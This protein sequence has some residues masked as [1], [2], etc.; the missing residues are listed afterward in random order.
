MPIATCKLTDRD[1]EILEL[2]TKRVRVLSL[3]QV[4]R[5]W[6]ARQAR[7][8]ENASR[9]LST[10]EQGGLIHR[11]SGFAHPE[12]PLEK[13]VATWS[14]GSPSPD[15][16]NLS[17]RLRTRWTDPL[18]MT[19]AFIGTK[20]AAGQ[21][22]GNGGRVPRPSELSHDLHLAGVFFKLRRSDPAKSRTW[23]SEASQYAKGGGRDERLPDAVVGKG[24]H[25][26]AIEFG[27][28][29]SKAKLI[30]FHEHCAAS[31]LPYEIW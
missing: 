30:E 18:R 15:F 5:E 23:L 4:A 3:E 21:F 27:G 1:M 26:T 25:R 28:A 7:A 10:L 6:W 12:L 14:P 9:R 22:G 16:G 17:Y 31:D 29:Y 13:P 20:L 11:F 8:S 24:R 2:L 19:Q